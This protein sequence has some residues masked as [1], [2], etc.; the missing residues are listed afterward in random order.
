MKTSNKIRNAAIGMLTLIFI[1]CTGTAS[2]TA[3]ADQTQ[4][5]Y[6]VCFSSQNYAVRNSNKMKQTD[7]G[8]YLLENKTLSS[9]DD[10]YV[11][12][13]AGTRYYRADDR[14]LSVE[15][16]AAFDYD[17]AFSP[18]AAFTEDGEW[19]ET[20]CNVSYRFYTPAEYSLMI[21][22]EPVALSYNPYNTAFDLYFLHKV[23]GGLCCELRRK[24]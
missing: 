6:Y 20:N 17:I 16:V 23:D 8:I 19:T 18:D 12:D 9:A 3:F 10:F 4:K 24:Q 1:S 11:T 7:D 13:N 22:E 5:N 21:G 15:E 14:P 2:V